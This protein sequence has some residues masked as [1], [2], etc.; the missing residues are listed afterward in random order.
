M[1]NT[2]LED[3]KISL[4][5]M[6]DNLGFDLELLIFLNSIKVNLVQLGVTELG[7]DID[8]TTNWPTFTDDTVGGL[9]KHYILVKAR[10]AF[11]PTASETI[12]KTFDKFVVELEGR[13][14]HEVEESV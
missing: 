7:I 12:A 2:I 5:V 9:T 14:A 1:A 11:D 13:L 10:Q 4:G 8:E 3:I 6:P